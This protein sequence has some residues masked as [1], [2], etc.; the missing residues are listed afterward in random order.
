MSNHAPETHTNRRQTSMTSLQVLQWMLMLYIVYLQ[1][2]GT[3]GGLKEHI[4]GSLA[5]QTIN[6]SFL[7]VI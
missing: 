3:V 4:G 7:P 5:L 6:T 2:Q 1:G